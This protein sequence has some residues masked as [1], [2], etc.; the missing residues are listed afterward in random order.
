[1]RLIEQSE[2]N[3]TFYTKDG[4]SNIMGGFRSEED[5]IK[6]AQQSIQKDNRIVGAEVDWYDG[7]NVKTVYSQ[8]EIQE[9]KRTLDPQKIVDA[10][11]DA[12]D[13]GMSKGEAWEYVSREWDI[14]DELLPQ[15]IRMLRSKHN[16]QYGYEKMISDQ[17]LR[18]GHTYNWDVHV[19]RYDEEYNRLIKVK[20]FQ[21]GNNQ[22]RLLPVEKRD[23]SAIRRKDITFRGDDEKLKLLLRRLKAKDNASD[24]PSSKNRTYQ[25]MIDTAK[26]KSDPYIWV[27]ITLW[28]NYKDGNKI[29]KY[30][31]SKEIDGIVTESLPRDFQ[32]FEIYGQ[33]DR[34]STQ[35]EQMIQAEIQRREDEL[36]DLYRDYQKDTRD[37]S[38]SFYNFAR[39]I[40]MADEGIV[41]KTVMLK[42]DLLLS[43]TTTLLEKGDTIEILERVRD[44][45]V[46][47]P[48]YSSAI[49]E[50]VDW[51]KEQ[52]LR[53]SEDDLFTYI[54]TGP[55]KPSDGKTNRFDILLYDDNELQNVPAKKMVHFQVYGMGNGKY[56]LNMYLSTA[57][58]KDY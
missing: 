15:V 13:K 19:G 26:D 9:S 23:G 25:Q 2:Y 41:E 27:W 38:T 45:E 52:G 30:E 50:V 11:E 56:E 58:I 54:S 28:N 20:L 36:Q 17:L 24:P 51:L 47:H 1:M 55:K 42:Q 40:V 5:A 43:G 8:G 12:M 57:K 14:T 31:K 16:W 35:Q 6:I 44:Y 18:R 29:M 33:S 53:M 46:Y 34:L 7:Y 22:W 3:I 21:Q 49:S 4:D 39:T 37:T 10:F 48:S 32:D